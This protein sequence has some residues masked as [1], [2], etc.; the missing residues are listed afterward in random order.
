MADHKRYSAGCKPLDA[1]GDKKNISDPAQYKR[2]NY[3]YGDLTRS[4]N[5]KTEKGQNDKRL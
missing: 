2:Y 4:Q 3:C 1:F 5:I